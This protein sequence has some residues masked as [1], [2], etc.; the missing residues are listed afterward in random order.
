[1]T[2]SEYRAIRALS[3]SS[4]KD[5]EVSPYRFWYHH[6]NPNRPEREASPQMD[7]GTALHCAILQPPEVFDSQYAC[8]LNAEE[9][10]DVLDTVDDMKEWLTANGLS[11]KGAKKKDDYI[12]LV[13]AYSPNQP[14]LSVLKSAH[15]A[16]NAGKTILSVDDWARLTGCVESLRSEPLVN[17]LLRDGEAEVPIIAVDPEYGVQQKCRIDWFHPGYTV[18]FKTFSTKG[19]KSVD[20]T[21][22]DAI[23][24][25]GYLNQG[26]F[27]ATLR[28]Q[29]GLQ[30]GS[31][32]TLK[33]FI[34]VFIESDPPYEVRIRQMDFTGADLYHQQTK[35]H[36]RRMVELYANC[37]ETYGE[38][39]WRDTQDI[40][41]VQD[42]N[43]RQLAWT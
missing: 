37:L 41:Q 34:N 13:Q 17:E 3:F 27:Y 7:F 15:A 36:V 25:E 30:D 5:L 28:Y 31:E 8:A 35:L 40:R 43:F 26:F 21:V 12:A 19:H 38:K 2:E 23:W 6:I 39:P 1:M 18:D 29:K 4:M 32:Q 9:I 10:P 20:E 24:Y 16:R 14:I 22:A 33:P 11:A 42:E